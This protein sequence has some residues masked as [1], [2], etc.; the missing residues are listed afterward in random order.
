MRKL[1]YLFLQ[2]YNMF[3]YKIKNKIK[4]LAKFLR[5]INEFGKYVLFTALPRLRKKHVI[6]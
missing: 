3:I 4:K 1:S 5:K 2:K 6:F